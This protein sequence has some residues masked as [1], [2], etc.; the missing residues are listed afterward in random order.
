E[1]KVTGKIDEDRL[2]LD[3]EKSLFDEVV[4]LEEAMKP[5]LSNSDY[6]ACL[7]L[8]SPLQTVV[9]GYFDA[10]MVMDEDL[11]LR[12]NRLALLARLKSLFDQ[13]ADLSVLGA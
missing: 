8:L 11:A 13:V 1:M 2:I 3:E 10:V 9:D 4:K 5:L 12:R 7:T 6:S